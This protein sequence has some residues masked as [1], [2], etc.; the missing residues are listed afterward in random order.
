MIMACDRAAY[1]GWALK[2]LFVLSRSTEAVRLVIGRC[3]TISI[4]ARRAI[5]VIGRI[6][7]LRFVDR[8]SVVINAQAVAMSVRIGN[9]PS[10][11]HFVGREAHAG[12]DVAR[13]K[14]G[15]LDFLEIV[16]RVSIEF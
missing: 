1:C 6:R 13:L 4:E 14:G 8:Q 5:A 16:N 12:H 3:T 2:I 15:L 9:E 7:T 10:L 11:E